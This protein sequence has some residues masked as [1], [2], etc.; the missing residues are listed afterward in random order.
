[1][2]DIGADVYC[3]A[4]DVG[5]R[6]SSTVALHG[7]KGVVAIVGLQVHGL[8]YGAPFRVKGGDGVEDLLGAG[9]AGGWGVEVVVVAAD[10]GAH[11]VRV[12]N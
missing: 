1:M 9:F 5:I 2:E 4:S 11:G 8:P 6:V 7:D 12:D 10:L 3:F